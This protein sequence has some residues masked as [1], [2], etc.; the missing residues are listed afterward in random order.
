ME[1][2]TII[3]PAED[4]GQR[5]DHVL[6]RTIP[7]LSRTRLQQLIAA[8]AVRV[9]GSPTEA[10]HRLHPSERIE[11]SVPEPQSSGLMPEQIPINVVYEDDDVLV[12]DKPAGLVV[13][14]AAGHPSGT[15]VNALLARYPSLAVGGSLRPGIVHRLDR[16][17]SGLM[18]IA[19][20]DRAMA[21]LTAQMRAHQILKEYT[22]LA[23]GRP[24]ASR[25]VIEAPIGRHPGDRKRMSVV[26]QGRPARTHFEVVET[27]PLRKGEEVSMLRL[28]LETGRTHQIRVHLAAIGHPIVGDPEYGRWDD[29]IPL[30]RQFLHASRLGFMLP[31]G[32][33]RE[34]HSPL[35][36]DLEALLKSLRSG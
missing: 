23:W 30:K 9:D 6:A 32:E 28:R 34:F 5:L 4:A 36:T 15:L 12:I 3:V 20:T 10:S 35:P 19:K 26:E 16:N 13:H 14:P 11:V 8:G 22:A 18:V 33:Y 21:S 24:E 1:H 2:R 7:E 25:G 29:A 17:T 31:D 27:I